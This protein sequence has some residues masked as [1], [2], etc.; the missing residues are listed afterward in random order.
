MDL[1]GHEKK[2]QKSKPTGWIRMYRSAETSLVLNRTLVIPHFVLGPSKISRHLKG[3]NP[4][5]SSFPVSPVVFGTAVIS[6]EKGAITLAAAHVRFS[7]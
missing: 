5:V 4:D 1:I 2:F 7:W 3:E 6:L